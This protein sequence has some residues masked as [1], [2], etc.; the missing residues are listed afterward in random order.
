VE[1]WFKKCLTDPPM[2]DKGFTIAV[3]SLN[4]S[5]LGCS[6]IVAD[7][8]PL[9]PPLS[10]PSFKIRFRFLTNDFHDVGDFNFELW[11]SW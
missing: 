6:L 2:S 11:W 9:G 4:L 3:F 8:I 5:G 7:N 10:T 1:Q